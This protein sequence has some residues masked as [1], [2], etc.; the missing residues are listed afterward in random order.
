MTKEILE[1][2]LKVAGVPDYIYNLTGKG[3]TDERL[4]LKKIQNKW[5][6]YYIE[7]GIKT[8]NEIFESEEDACQFLYAQLMN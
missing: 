2:K 1:K 8:T 3:R 4:C 7:R 6:V 5:S